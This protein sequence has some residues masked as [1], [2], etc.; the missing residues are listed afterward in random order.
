MNEKDKN[1]ELRSEKVRNITGKIPPV[2]T[3]YGISIVA[4][5]L[6]VLFIISIIIPY[7]EQVN[8]SITVHEEPNAEFIKAPHAGTIVIDSVGL[9]KDSVQ[10][11]VQT[12]NIIYA[13][14]K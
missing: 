12:S 2:F 5:T 13:I 3:R 4:V 14:C 11:Y 7:R 9:Q 8:L 1:I 6:F 10:I